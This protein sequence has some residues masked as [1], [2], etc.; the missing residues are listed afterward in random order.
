MIAPSTVPKTIPTAF[1]RP[2]YLFT[3]VERTAGGALYAQRTESG[4]LVAFEVHRIRCREERR[5]GGHVI[6][7]GEYLA[8][9]EEWGRHGWTYSG[10]GAFERA[11]AKMTA[12]GPQTA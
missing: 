1:R 8:R 2:A 6:E 3:L 10:T 5:I 12:L 11:K 9:S 7:A 4:R